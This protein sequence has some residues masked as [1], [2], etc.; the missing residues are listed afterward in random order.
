MNRRVIVALGGL[1]LLAAGCAS[2]GDKEAPGIPATPKWKG[3]AYRL[4]FDAM[5]AK[6]NPAGIT[7]PGIK[8]TANPEALE[9]RVTLVVHYDSSEVKSDNLIINQ[10]TLA[11]F[12][13]SGTEGTLSADTLDNADKGLA[14]LLRGYCMKPKVKISVALARSSLAPQADDNEINNKRLSDWQ[15]VEVPYK[16]LKKGCS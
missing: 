11:P 5:P 13:I 12:D 3:P 7:L 10:V 9:R 1:V 16:N 14:Q 2:Q 15:T 6:P 4:T 8:F